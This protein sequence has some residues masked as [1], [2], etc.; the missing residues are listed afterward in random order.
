[1]AKTGDWE[2]VDDDVITVFEMLETHVNRPD[3]D[4]FVLY[5]TA[6]VLGQMA[7]A[8]TTV[9]NLRRHDHSDGHPVVKRV[10][11]QALSHLETSPPFT[12]LRNETSQSQDVLHQREPY[13]I[14]ARLATFPT[15]MAL[16]LAN[17]VLTLLRHTHV[18]R[19]RAW[20]SS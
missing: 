15:A 2:D 10:A 20:E 19:Q 3:P 18:T 14:L 11:A 6:L 16:G 4:E 7:P 1:M 17:P 13:G 5:F 9:K 8:K 12:S